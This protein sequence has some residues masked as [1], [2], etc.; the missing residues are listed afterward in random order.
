MAKIYLFYCL[1]GFV[2]LGYQVVWFRIYAD[3]FGS[4]NL[5]F[6]LVLCNFI[7][8]LGAGALA[9]RRLTDRLATAL[10]VGD[11]LRIYGIVELLVTTSIMLTV[12]TALIPADTWGSFPYELRDGIYRQV[13]GY[14]LSKLAIAT[15]CVFVPCF[16][17]GV[18]FPL[19]CHVHGERGRFPAALYA[20]NT[21]GACIGVLACQF[22]F[23]PRIG[24]D[25]T[26]RCMAALNL[27]IGLFFVATG[28]AAAPSTPDASPVR[29]GR[30]EHGA[31]VLIT[32]AVLSGLIAGA[33][34]GDMFKRADF[35]L[36]HYPNGAAAMSCISLWAILAI[37]LGSCLVHAL[38]WMRLVHIKLA[39]IAAL[40]GYYVITR[41]SVQYWILER[42]DYHPQHLWHVL[43]LVGFLV[44]PTFLLMSLLLPYVCNRLHSN[45]RHLGIAYGAN[46]ICF[47]L[48]VVAFTWLAP[49]VNVFYSMKLI[50]MVLAIGVALLLVMSEHHSLAWWKPA[51]ALAA[52][53]VACAITPSQFDP[54][55][56]KP[57]AMPARYPVRALKS[58]GAHTTFV[59]TV[60]A[61]TGKQLY[62]AIWFDGHV[63]SGTNHRSHVYMRLMA[64]F[65]LLAQQHPRNALLI[66]YGVGNTASAIASHDT[67]EHIDA[68]DL[69]DKVFE[70]A[71]EFGYSSRNVHLDPRLRFIHDDG[72]NYLKVT[73]RVYDLVTSEPPPPMKAGTYR[74]YSKQYYEQV[75]ARLS[76]QGM[77]TQ[78]LPTYQ[79]PP[80]AA[81]LAVSTFV[82]VFP[83]TLM[84]SGWGDDFILVGSRSPID[85]S[86]IERRYDQQPRAVADLR[87]LKIRRPLSLLARVVMDDTALRRTYGHLRVISDQ[88]NDLVY[89]FDQPYRWTVVPYDPYAVLDY[90]RGF[91]LAMEVDLTGVLMHFGRLRYYA[92]QFPAL[93]LIS[94]PTR[95]GSAPALRDVDWP[96]VEALERRAIKLFQRNAKDEAITL[97][98]RALELAEEQPDLLLRLAKLYIES[99]R[100]EL[101]IEPAERFQQIEPDEELGYFVM[102]VAL[103]KQQRWREALEQ[104]DQTIQIRPGFDHARMLRDRMRVK[105]ERTN[106]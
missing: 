106:Q 16:F 61:P 56:Y 39:A 105:I 74:L 41:S 95:D 44:F 36:G 9:S 32:C 68:V 51:G 21:L 101:A 18:T 98:R 52:L 37:F 82:S 54:G 93:S 23:L 84:F 19:L 4:T 78:W 97:V 55:F 3:R 71:P 96:A 87:R 60:S 99:D 63:M 48:G 70:T 10:R 59:V 43:I 31:G 67:I 17:M 7:L 40:L 47:C 24:H 1:S 66:C 92:E 53:V 35:Y 64:H 25:D 49:L 75:L 103:S 77:M 79:M 5:T 34:E 65:P 104:F 42:F 80:E 13:A 73:D 57:D 85:L 69:N 14:Q 6:V 94:A 91:G 20:W 38:S 50:F 90:L 45:H 30:S 46:T 72:R 89:M 58:N 62:Q 11:R 81:D 33:L 12:V 29:A 100:P 86:N 83:H 22:Y 27:L 102:G 8:G 15:V 26:L 2:S 88:H 76:P 28:G